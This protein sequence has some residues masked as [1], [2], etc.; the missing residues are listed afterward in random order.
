MSIDLFFRDDSII[1]YT[2]GCVLVVLCGI[3][4]SWTDHFHEGMTKEYHL[5]GIDENS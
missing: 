1:G 4:E 5:L 3:L 2:N